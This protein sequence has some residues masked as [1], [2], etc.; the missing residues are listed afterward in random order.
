MPKLV[1]KASPIVT[2]PAPAPP[3][4]PAVTKPVKPAL[5]P[6]VFRKPV[7]PTPAPP[8]PDPEPVEGE[9]VYE[10]TPQDQ[11]DSTYQGRLVT[12][13]SGSSEPDSTGNVP[14]D[15]S[16][17]LIPTPAVKL[18]PPNPTAHLAQVE[19]FERRDF[20]SGA[21][22]AILKLRF[23]DNDREDN[24]TIWLPPLFVTNFMEVVAG[25]E[26]TLPNEEGD[27][28]ATPPVKGN[29]QLN[30]YLRNVAS[31]DKTAV[32]QKLMAIGTE[33]GHTRK[34]LGIDAAP[35]SVD[36][37]FEI[38][39]AILVGVRVIALC[40]KDRNPQDPA[41]ANNLRVQGVLAPSVLDD[42]RQKML[43]PFNG[44]SGYVFAWEA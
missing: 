17:D 43:K 21:V 35:D 29:M 14:V 6:A 16:D 11:P 9:I 27:R 23:E 10:E 30:Q 42:P 32:M 2:K 24:F 7:A 13:Q 40:R 5:A 12:G 41:F 20:D 34:Q 26:G 22:A 36:S 37:W 8:L 38:T 28:D 31:G 1:K 44:K 25:P 19:G 33:Q 4:R 39:N 18:P 3:A 15:E